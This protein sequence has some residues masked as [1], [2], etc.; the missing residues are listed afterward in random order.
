ML[1]QLT[2]Q[3]KIE[4]WYPEICSNIYCGASIPP[5]W[6]DIVVDALEELRNYPISIAQIKEKF[7]GLRI[8]Y[9]CAN[10]YDSHAA[11]CANDIIED[12]VCKA[13]RITLALA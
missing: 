13:Q 7:G 11:M 5:E 4:K 9:D 8:Y 10:G 6:E 1:G 2:F 12:A 3:E